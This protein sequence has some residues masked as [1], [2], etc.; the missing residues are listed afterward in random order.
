MAACG[1]SSTSAL[2]T[3]TNQPPASSGRARGVKS[4]CTRSQ[5][6]RTDE[7]AQAQSSSPGAVSD[8]AMAEADDEMVGDDSLGLCDMPD[9]VLLHAHTHP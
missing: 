9:E 6:R 7:A 4:P 1:A 5:T 8:A 3:L 2:S